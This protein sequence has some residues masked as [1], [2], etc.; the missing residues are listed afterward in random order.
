M[1]KNQLNQPCY[2]ETFFNNE[3][4]EKREILE[5]IFNS[6]S[7]CPWNCGVNRKENEQGRCRA[8]NALKVAKALPH[9]GEEPV[10]TGT[11]GSGTIFFTY[12]HL[13][14]TFCQNYQISQENLGREMT[15]DELAFSMLS[16]QE[17]GCH[18]INLVSP[19][20]FLP[21]IVAALEIAIPAGLSLPLV[22]N[23]NGYE[24]VETLKLL[25]GIID[26]YLPDAK[27]ADDN[28][29]WYFSRANEYSQN[30]LCALKEMYRQVGKLQLNQEGMAERGLIIRH[31]VLPHHLSNTRKVL[32]SIKNLFGNKIHISLMGQYFPNPHALHDPFLSRKLTAEEYREAINYL[33]EMNFENGW[34][35][36]P[37][38]LDRSFVPDFTKSESW[39]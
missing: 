1:K 17:Q 3:L 6:C 9:F 22:Y 34:L 12:C 24:S 27:Y 5:E 23:S 14:C 4:R 25:D 15:T 38:Q 37:D 19:T 29:A 21:H 36:E 32:E 2:I 10:L 35:Q 11:H 39:N 31:L 30:N 7:L 13:Q 33:E 16:L 8:G 20:H 26:I 28:L 18:N